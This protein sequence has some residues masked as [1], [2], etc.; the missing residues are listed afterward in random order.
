VADSARLTVVPCEF[1]SVG[2]R[3]LVRPKT[4]KDKAIHP[5]AG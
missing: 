2:R 3:Q 4:I 1:M 5:Q